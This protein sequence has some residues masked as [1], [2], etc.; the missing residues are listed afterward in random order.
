MNEETCLACGHEH[1]AEREVCG[2]SIPSYNRD[3]QPDA[4]ECDRCKCSR[5]MTAQELIGR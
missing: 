5:C 1:H 2:E 4:C 3:V